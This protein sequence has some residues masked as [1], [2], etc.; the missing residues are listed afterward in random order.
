MLFGKCSVVYPQPWSLCLDFPIEALP[1]PP[2]KEPR[3]QGSCSLPCKGTGESGP[4]SGPGSGRGSRG[5]GREGGHSEAP[6]PPWPHG[7]APQPRCGLAGPMGDAPSGPGMGGS[8]HPALTAEALLQASLAQAQFCVLDLQ[9]AMEVSQQ[10]LHLGPPASME[11]EDEAEE[12]DEDENKEEEG[13]SGMEEQ[14]EEELEQLF[15]TNPLFHAPHMGT[16]PSQQAGWGV[17]AYRPHP[18]EDP[19]QGLAD[20]PQVGG[21]WG[22]GEELPAGPPKDSVQELQVDASPGTPTGHREA[23]L[24]DPQAARLINPSRLWGVLAPQME[25]PPSSPAPGLPSGAAPSTAQEG[26]AQPQVAGSRQGEV[27]AP[28]PS[29]PAAMEEAEEPP[30]D[31]PAQPPMEKEDK[32]E[33]MEDGGQLS[34]S[35]PTTGGTTVAN[36]EALGM[37]EAR[38]AA[39]S[40][41]A[42]LYHLDG[43]KRSQVASYLRKNTA[44][45]Q[46]VA[47]EYVAFFHFSGQS[48]DQA[49]RTFLSAFVLTG[50]T[51]ERERILRHFSSHFH[52]ANPHAFPSP[53]AV[54]TLTCALMLLNTDLHGPNLGRSMTCNQFV[55]NLDGLM[56]N[57]QNFPKEQLKALYHSIRNQKLEWAVHADFPPCPGDLSTAHRQLHQGR[58]SRSVGLSHGLSF[59][60]PWGRRG[61]KTFYTILKGNQL[62]FLKAENETEGQGA[63]E[64]LGVHHALAEHESQYSKRPHVFRLQTADWRIVLFQAPSAEEMNSWVARINLVAAALSAP[65]FPAAVGSQRKF[66]RPVLPTAPSRGSLEEQLRAHEAWLAQAVAELGELQ[67]SLPEPRSRSRGLDDYRLRKDYLLYERRRLETYVRVLEARLEGGAVGPGG[68]EDWLE[69]PPP[70]AEL[71]RAQSSPSLARPTPASA[72]VKRNVSERRTIRRVIVPRRPRPPL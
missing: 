14:E 54:H 13:S 19:A 69:P 37:T 64:P 67:R 71:P 29:A 6:A 26:S 1:T 68:W 43:F 60:A 46:A 38:A 49:L 63:E 20:A 15:H 36:G 50:E 72:K 23:G 52:Q 41:A 9:N 34:F 47:E 48:L 17:P 28:G 3:T 62:Y 30:P 35:A 44:F 11:E 8:P 57:R 21:A 18:P 22:Q 25:Q 4:G 31:P 10:P 53:D 24:P 61:W 12:E 66:V 45:S 56:D 2:G 33:E 58:P 5:R 55:A 65:P 42:R 39:R 40:L 27:A 51:Q 70:P 16:S 7:A 59:A 32:E